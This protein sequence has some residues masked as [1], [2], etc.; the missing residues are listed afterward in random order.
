MKVEE[1]GG[2]VMVIIALLVISVIALKGSETAVG[3]LIGILSSGG[4]FY[5]RGKVQVPS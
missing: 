2:L 3:A 5:L 4:A 1:L